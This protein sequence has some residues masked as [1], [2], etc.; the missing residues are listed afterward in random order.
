MELRKH[1]DGKAITE[2]KEELYRL[3]EVYVKEVQILKAQLKKAEDKCLAKEKEWGSKEKSFQDKIA[4]FECKA[5]EQEESCSAEVAELKEAL[6][7]KVKEAENLEGE[8]TKQYKEGF[9][10]AI[11]QVKFLYADLVVSSYC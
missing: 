7:A 3:R 6:A 10:E 11:N 1:F 9:D 5:K 8:A 4:V 2:L